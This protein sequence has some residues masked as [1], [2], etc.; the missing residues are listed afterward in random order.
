MFLCC[1]PTNARMASSKERDPIPTVLTHNTRQWEGCKLPSTFLH[2]FR[3]PTKNGSNG[4]GLGD[5]VGGHGY[6]PCSF[7]YNSK[8]ICFTWR[9]IYLF[10]CTATEQVHMRKMRGQRPP[11]CS[12]ITATSLVSHSMAKWQ[13]INTL[14]MCIN[15]ALRVFWEF[16][17]FPR[18]PSPPRSMRHPG[19]LQN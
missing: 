16:P 7:I 17:I 18:S 11:N 12:L 19:I 4:H 13:V 5:N 3:I 15:Y 2:F 1:E 10:P 6:L 9:H 8:K 14:R